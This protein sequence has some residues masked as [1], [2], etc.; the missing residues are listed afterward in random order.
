MKQLRKHKMNWPARILF[1]LVSFFVLQS[2]II[3]VSASSINFGQDYH[4]GISESHTYDEIERS[5]GVEVD[6]TGRLS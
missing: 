1:I 6:R 3:P 2:S 5:I 4:I